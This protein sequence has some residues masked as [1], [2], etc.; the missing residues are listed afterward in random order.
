MSLDSKTPTRRPTTLL[1]PK[2]SVLLL[3]DH[4]P[5]MVF[6]VG[7]IERQQLVNNVVGL[8]KTARVFG[9]PTILTSIAADSFS[10]PLLEEIRAVF[11]E[12]PVIDRSK[13]NAWE[14]DRVRDAVLGTGR[15][16][17]LMAGLWSEVCLALP[18]ISALEEGRSVY[19]VT[20]ASGG[21]S[22]ESAAYGI[23]R[24]VQAG[25]VPVTWL[26]V[27]SELQRDWAR[28]ETYEAVNQIVMQHGGAWG[29]GV[30][31]VRAGFSKQAAG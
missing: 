9:I 10:G 28:K 5:Q 12:L 3:V 18:A 4:Q 8:A 15:R 1:D 25:G 13:I 24:I 31:Y 17:I 6:G 2:E 21:P 26:Q 7:S 14:D 29:Q 23:E 22:R 30:R 11:P 16:Q 19:A 20:D 27:L